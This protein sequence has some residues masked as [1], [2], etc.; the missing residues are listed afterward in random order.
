M[1]IYSLLSFLAFIINIQMAYYVYKLN[2]RS[3][4]N[5]SFLFSSFTNALIDLAFVFY[6][7][8]ESKELARLWY[9]ISSVCWFP[10]SSIALH[11]I[12]RLTLRQKNISRWL[13]A[14]IYLPGVVFVIKALFKMFF[15]EDFIFNY[16]SWHTVLYTSSPWF[17]IYIIYITVVITT[18][19]ILL[20]YWKNTTGVELEK[21]QADTIIKTSS[22]VFPA[23]LLTN[24]ILPYLKIYIIPETGHILYLFF[25]IGIVY[26]IVHY[27]FMVP[28]FA[29]ENVLDM[30]SDL[31][32]MVDFNAKI[33]KINQAVERLLEYKES[34]IIGK[35]IETVIVESDKI[36]EDINKIKD[37]VHFSKPYELNYRSK[38]GSIIPVTISGSLIKDTEGHNFGCVFIGHDLRQNKEL[39]LETARRLQAEENEKR[40]TQKILF[41]SK[42]AFSMIELSP[43]EDLYN[44][45]AQKI[46]ELAGDCFVF[47]S[48]FHHVY[49]GAQIRAFT[50]SPENILK[51]NKI[52]GSTP[53]GL[54]FKLDQDQKSLLDSG[55]IIEMPAGLY[56]MSSGMIPI[57]L[58]EQLEHTFQLGNRY[59]IGFVKKG[60]FFGTAEILMCQKS[61]LENQL[62]IETFVRQGILAIA[63]KESE[64]KEILSSKSFQFLL[65]SLKEL[66]ESVKIEELYGII[67]DRLLNFVFDSMILIILYDK[68]KEVMRIDSINGNEKYIQAL[69]KILKKDING[70]KIKMDQNSVREI[71]D[72]GLV[73]LKGGL[74]ELTNAMITQHESGLVEKMLDLR[75][76]YRMALKKSGNLIGLVAIMTRN[77][78]NINTRHVVEIFIHQA[79]LSF[80][81]PKKK[82]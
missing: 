64:R 35:P 80:C 21:K 20:I 26:A 72:D 81:L 56:N 32:I 24:V 51:F 7:S 41:L 45:I 65:N 44:Y 46:Y 49:Q 78:I 13:F 73:H 75:N 82:L 27:K 34:E 77:S 61:A 14:L 19:L 48:K 52:L 62:V 39:H 58:C 5:T 1:N 79:S 55:R 63:N 42:A 23:I 18:G 43:E 68:K 71:M 36:H 15:A 38:K 69:H 59:S 9:L 12:I 60:D 25:L 33:L 22:V 76:V 30:L 16:G 40:Y 66:T 54:F 74:F 37:E 28:S 47:V 2:P 11:F 3:K 6:Y 10:L 57:D 17:W 67:S 70:L 4:L 29:E 8:A 31:L 50:G 53:I